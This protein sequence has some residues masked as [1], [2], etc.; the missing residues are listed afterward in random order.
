M[1]TNAK[2]AEALRLGK[3]G[4]PAT[5]EERLL[6]E[7]WMRGHC[8]ALCATW[9]GT[10]YVS[11]A[12]QGG[13]VDPRAMNTRQIFAAWRDR[14]ALATHDAEQAAK[15]VPAD[16]RSAA[17]R[18]REDLGPTGS[19]YPD[20]RVLLAFAE[21]A[22]AAPTPPAPEAETPNLYVPYWQGGLTNEDLERWFRLKTKAE[23][24]DRDLSCFALGVE[25]GCGVGRAPKPEKALAVQ[26][27]Q[28]APEAPE[29]AGQEQGGRAAFESAMLA[30]DGFTTEEEIAA[31]HGGYYL[32]HRLID[33]EIGWKAA[34]SYA[35][36]AQAQQAAGQELP[37]PDEAGDFAPNAKVYAASVVRA[38]LAQRREPMTVPHPGS[39][40]AE[41]MIDSELALRD[42]PTNTFNAARAGYEACRKL[43]GL[44][45]GATTGKEPA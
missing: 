41:A 19:N 25:V 6:F 9:N 2:L 5:E 1:S 21:Q 40:E 8:W 15:A 16:L 31:K 18:T 20:V 22:L 43:A 39:P 35:R 28:A 26:A 32:Y 10:Q 45:A 44:G 30:I 11:D 37:E 36:A 14:A 34:M 12:E 27:A 17:E 24:T 42:W 33:A 38:A 29:A 7:A 13:N 23:P 3:E 4:A